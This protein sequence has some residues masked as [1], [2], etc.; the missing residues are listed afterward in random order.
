MRRMEAPRSSAQKC[1]ACEGDGW[2]YVGDW[3]QGYPKGKCRVCKGSGQMKKDRRT[4]Q[5][6]A[7]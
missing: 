5:W 4:G 1:S 2:Y 3:S 6:V 7:A